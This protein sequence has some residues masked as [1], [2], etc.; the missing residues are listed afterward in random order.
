MNTSKFSNILLDKAPKKINNTSEKV[1]DVLFDINEVVRELNSIDFCNPL[2]YILTKTLPPDGI[3]DRKL[4]EYSKLVNKF[5]SKSTQKLEFSQNTN[6][7][8]DDIEE[9]RISLE[10]LI[11]DE[12]IKNIIPG[13]DSILKTLQSLN[14]S[15]VITNTLLNPTQKKKLIQSFTNRLIPLSNPVNLAEIL[16]SS[17]VDNLNKKLRNLIKPERFRQDLL[18]LIKTVIQIDKSI[19][20]IQSVVLLMNKIIKSINVLIKI[21]KIT[22]KILKKTP[23]PAKYVTV[24]TTVTT[25]TKTSKLENNINELEKLLNSVSNFLSKVIIKQIRRIRNEIFML[26]IGLNQLYENLNSCNYFNDDLILD[27]I[28]NSINSLNNNI[29]ELDELFPELNIQTTS[30]NSNIYKGYNIIILKEETTDNNTSLFRRRVIVTNS[31]NILEYESTPTYTT[32]DQILIKEGQFYIDTKSETN[33]TDKNNNNLNDEEALLLIN[34]SGYNYNNLEEVDEQEKESQRLLLNQIRNNPEDN[35]LYNKFAKNNNKV[36][37]VKRIINSLTKLNTNPIVL[38]IRLER[39]SK[40]LLD[41][42]FTLEEIQNGFKSKFE[43]KYNIV[44]VNNNIKI[45]NKL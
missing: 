43:D 39:L 12:E 6:E 40:S 26:L 11:P 31:S 3:I 10:E 25:S 20:R 29:N 8:I 24:G 41:K 9:L 33:T 5:I 18:K 7:L 2:G 28:Q 42:G 23:I 19:S 22:I 27:E 30:S 34:Q 1:L 16:I 36:D 14:D 32:N 44:I 45:N 21:T 35:L 37:Q 17:Q 4:K 38:K 13:G 15:L